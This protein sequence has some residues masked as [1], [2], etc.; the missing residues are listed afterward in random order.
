MAFGVLFDFTGNSN[1]SKV[2]S[3]ATMVNQSWF[4]DAVNHHKPIDLFVIIGHNP[5]RP[6]VSSSTLDT[7]FN[8]IRAIKPD[9]P[10]QI[11]GGHT[12]IRDFAVYDDKTT[13]LESGRYC[14]TLGWLSMTGIN[15]THFRGTKYPKGVP[16]PTQKAV[17]TSISTASAHLAS[18]TSPSNLTYFRRYLD[19]NRVTFEYHA[20]GSQVKTFDTGLGV[21]VT[22][23]ITTVRKELNLTSLYGCA[24]QTWCVSCQP[25]LS[26]GNIYSLLT[27]ALSA[28]IINQTRADIP[29]LI[30]LN[31]GS[32]RFDLVKGPFTYDDSFIVSPFTDAF[33]FIP[34]VPYSLASVSTSLELL[35][36]VLT[37]A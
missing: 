36:A 33:Q 20:A 32:I 21:A 28:T 13:A 29:R 27:E 5:V 4:T 2:I 8:A 9:T 31:T 17:K 15:S 3:A 35:D 24:P 18:S 30:I 22:E 6:T 12:H 23:N 1:A 25:F 14:E 19:W 11:F 37:K 7:V 10:I 34:N 26:S 16:H